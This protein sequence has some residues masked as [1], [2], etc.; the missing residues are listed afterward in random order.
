MSDAATGLAGMR[1]HLRD[2]VHWVP[3]GSGGVHAVTSRGRFTLPG[4]DGHRWVTRLTP[5]LDGTHTVAQLTASVPPERRAKVEEVLRWL[6][7]HGLVRDL[8]RERPHTLTDADQRRYAGTLRYLAEHTEAA[9]HRFQRYRNSPVLVVGA[10]AALV[11]LLRATLRAGSRQVTV[12]DTGAADRDRLVDVVS[13]AVRVDPDQM[14]TLLDGEATPELVG[15]VDLVM[16]VAGPDTLPRA[17]KLDALCAD[18]GAALCQAVIADGEAWL[19]PVSDPDDPAT[20]WTAAWRRLG[21][22]PAAAPSLV[23]DGVLD[24]LAAQL[25]LRCLRRLTGIDDAAGHTVVRLDTGT[26]GTSI[27]P[28]TPHP[29][30]VP[31]TAQTAGDFSR[32]IAE[33]RAAPEAGDADF[34]RA[35]SSLVDEHTGVLTYLGERS[36]QQLPL[37]VTEATVTDPRGVAATVHGAATGFTTARHRAARRALELYAS[38]MF[39]RRRLL[40][41]DG[42]VPDVPPPPGDGWL[43]GWRL[44]DRGERLVPASAVFTTAPGGPHLPA[45]VASGPT[46]A[47]AVETGLLRL[48]RELTV[49]DALTA[50]GPFPAVELDRA[51]L[52][53]TALDEAG[54]RMLGILR[55]F[56]APVTA[57]DITGALGVPTYAVYLDGRPVAY[58]AGWSPADALRDGLE[59]AVLACQSDLAGEPDYRPP[60]VPGLLNRAR[61][62]RPSPPPAGYARVVDVLAARVGPPVAVPLDHDP[63]LATALPFAVR[64]VAGP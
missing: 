14:C 59:Q 42:T 49:A 15:A 60:P 51:G 40:A 10:G 5:F 46:W 31:A 3:T 25:V 19:G 39:D 7:R 58:A 30:A 52:D 17:E 32:R 54:Q 13:A 16:H 21:T 29:L 34:S 27:H 6:H 41:A 53:G 37:W 57:Y 33:L 11:T 8:S 36:F 44:D 48:C 20:Q 55:L 18:R 1:P 28:F 45:G 56:R 2:G 26:L 23:D 63:A 62:G 4:G 50:A 22:W 35:A 24:L 38:A 64:V 9:G 12:V 43:R 47:A 61:E